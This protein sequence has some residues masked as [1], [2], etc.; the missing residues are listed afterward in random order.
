MGLEA[1]QLPW[2]RA[3]SLLPQGRFCDSVTFCFAT[4]ARTPRSPGETARKQGSFVVLV[5][6]VSFII[7]TKS[8]V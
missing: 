1:P 4:A 7:R 6:D 3:G 5:I 8:I 2:S